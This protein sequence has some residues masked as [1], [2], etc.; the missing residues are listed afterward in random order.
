MS[1]EENEVVLMSVMVVLWEQFWNV[2]KLASP[3]AV[4]PS[5]FGGG[6]LGY[7]MY[8]LIHYFLHHGAASNAVSQRLK[9][10][11]IMRFFFSP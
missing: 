5:I 8:D 2:L 11:I 6:L 3:A 10:T 4:G 7:V 9:V 1:D